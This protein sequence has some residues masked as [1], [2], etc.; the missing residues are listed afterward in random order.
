VAAANN[1]ALLFD[2]WHEAAELDALQFNI[3]DCTV[4][5]VGMQLFLF[6]I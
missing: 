2:M 4:V 1:I 6:L 5:D 3:N